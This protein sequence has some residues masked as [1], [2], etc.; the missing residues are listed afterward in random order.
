MKLHTMFT[1]FLPE[2]IYSSQQ[3]YERVDHPLLVGMHVTTEKAI[4]DAMDLNTVVDGLLGR[5]LV[6]QLPN[7]PKLKPLSRLSSEPLPNEIRKK[8]SGIAKELPRQNVQNF[9]HGEPGSQREESEV[10]SRLGGSRFNVISPT[11]EAE[12]YFEEIRQDFEHRAT[13]GVAAAL[14]RRA[15]EQVIRV[16]GVVAFGHAV[17]DNT[18][19]SPKITKEILFWARDLVVH[20]LSELVPL[21]E[22]H[23]ADGPREKLQK[24]ILR[25]LRQLE[26]RA[27]PERWVRKQ[28]MM[29]KVKGGGRNYFDL[30]QEVQ[31]LIDVGDIEI[32]TGE[33]G[34]PQVPAE[35]RTRQ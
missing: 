21:A 14:W 30:K 29:Q 22:Q 10:V 26:E 18:L 16:A 34:V 17:M 4:F 25:N 3:P 8:I 31:A 13:E 11:K 19:H 33:G 1:K 9:L 32:R 24:N 28:D 27:G 5:F 35:C 2:R 15:Y 6:V 20:C 12:P 23:A 7:T